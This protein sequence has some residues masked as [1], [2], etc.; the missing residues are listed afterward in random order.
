[1]NENSVILISLFW[2]FFG[3]LG[4]TVNSYE[5]SSANINYQC[6]V[7]ITITDAT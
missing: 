2:F 6:G 7:L 4:A 3:M 1:M 5:V